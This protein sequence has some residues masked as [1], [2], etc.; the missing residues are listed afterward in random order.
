MSSLK[1]TCGFM[2]QMFGKELYRQTCGTIYQWQ[3]SLLNISWKAYTVENFLKKKSGQN[4][5]AKIH[6]IQDSWVSFL[7][8][9]TDCVVEYTGGRDQVYAN[10][11]ECGLPLTRAHPSIS[12]LKCLTWEKKKREREKEMD[13]SIIGTFPETYKTHISKMITR[14]L[15]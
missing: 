2:G 6:E 14:E 1:G 9:L 7:R 12:A 4:Y 13:L 11:H 15:F 3:M 5:L 10:T 8:Y